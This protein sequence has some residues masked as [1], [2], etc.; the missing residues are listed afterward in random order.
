MRGGLS[1]EIVLVSD[2][3][4]NLE[5]LKSVSKNMPQ[6]P[7]YCIGDFVGYG[8]NP[9]EAIQWAKERE[10]TAVIGNHD[11]ATIT[12]D[13]EWFNKE[14]AAAIEWTRKHISTSGKKYLSSLPRRRVV[15]IGGLKMLMVHG[16]P[17]DTLFEYV[18][19]ATHEHLFNAYL[20]RFKVDII[21]MGH[22]HIP[23]VWEGRK[24]FVV[25]PGSVGQPRSGG[26]NASYLILKVEDKR[27]EFEH[28]PTPYDTKAAAEKIRN[29]ELPVFLAERLFK[30]V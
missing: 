29:A 8:A 1:L 14:A 30:G 28:R 3:H 10:V 22:T 26:P 17:T 19:P 7:I 15:K 6:Q 16:S 13:T 4:S 5:A 24:G 9:N 20:K 2:I 12:G 11:Y 27:V 21:V 18:H 23:F 25:N